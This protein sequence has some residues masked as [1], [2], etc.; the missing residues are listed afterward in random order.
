MINKTLYTKVLMICLIITGVYYTKLLVMLM[1]RDLNKPLCLSI[2][3][4]L[5]S[6]ANKMGKISNRLALNEGLI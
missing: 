1:V 5:V 2:T 6:L 4:I 3:H